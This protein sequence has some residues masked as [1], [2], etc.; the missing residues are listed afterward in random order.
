MNMRDKIAA[1]VRDYEHHAGHEQFVDAV[2][3]AIIAALDTDALVRAALE[4]TAD[5]IAE[6]TTSQH[7]AHDIRVGI[8]PDQSPKREAMSDDIRALADD[9]EAMAA[10]M[11][12]A[13]WS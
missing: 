13:G 3:D 12:K 10:I 11:R 9:P 1:V 8:F 4:R 7:V 5:M 6:Y 2:T